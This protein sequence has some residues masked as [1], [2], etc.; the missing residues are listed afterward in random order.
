VLK[1]RSFVKVEKESV[2]VLC[3]QPS[4]LRVEPLLELGL[5]LLKPP[6]SEFS[7]REKVA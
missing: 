6:L 4:V 7:Q 2:S 1:L 3:V 5:F